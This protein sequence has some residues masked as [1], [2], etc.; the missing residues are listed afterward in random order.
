MTKT[1]CDICG[2]PIAK[3]QHVEVL[4][5]IAESGDHPATIEKTYLDIHAS[6]VD[7]ILA[8]LA[9]LFPAKKD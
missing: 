6:H 5:D 7:D 1:Y 8:A 4:I 9:K 3:G 2:K